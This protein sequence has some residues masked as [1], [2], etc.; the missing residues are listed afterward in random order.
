MVCW[1]FPFNRTGLGIQ[2]LQVLC[3]AISEPPYICRRPN[4]WQATEIHP[5][6]PGSDTLLLEKNSLRSL[7]LVHSKGT[8]LF[9]TGIDALP[10][11]PNGCPRELLLFLRRKAKVV[12]SHMARKW[13]GRFRT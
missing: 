12:R 7:G 5:E 6:M 1:E 10:I 9:A 11:S 13:L 4:P 2:F 8:F 3:S